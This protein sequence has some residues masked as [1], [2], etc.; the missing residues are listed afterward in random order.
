[1]RRVL[2]GGMLAFLFSAC[3]ISMSREDQVKNLLA[4]PSLAKSEREAL[5]GPFFKRTEWPEK[6]WWEYYGSEELNRLVALALKNNPTIQLVQSRI[7]FAREKALQAR[8]KLFPLIYFNVSDAWQYLSENGLYRALND[9]IQLS[10]QDIDFSLSFSYEFDFWGKYRNL[11]YAALGREKAVEAE[12][13][14]AELVVSTALAQAYFALKTNLARKKLYEKLYAVRKDLWNLQITLRDSA[15]ASDLPQLLSEEG[16]LEAKQWLASIDE[17]IAINRHVVNILAGRGPDESLVL[18][19]QL[20]LLPRKLALPN[21]LSLEL[22]SRRPDLM[23]EV[24]RMD[25]LAREVGA[26]KADFWPNINLTALLGFESG[27][28]TELFQWASKTVGVTP[29]LSLPVYTAGAI[30]A[31]VGEKRALFNEAVYQY[32]ELVLRSFQEVADLIAMGR[33]IYRQ[34]EEQE[35]IVRRSEMRYELVQLRQEHGIDDALKADR[36][37][38][39]VLQKQLMDVKLLYNQYLVS[40][41]L[42]KALG[43]GYRG[44]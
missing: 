38:E 14:Q 33:S 28:W 41:R 34:K 44:H 11:Y 32:N 3:T 37:L 39:E 25:A 31:N 10:N 35:A 43:G 23:A 18:E 20:P 1:M 40:V 19:P 13:V 4:A 9:S 16:V 7:T 30:A 24:W 5:A 22:L 12:N 29:G 36:F 2:L 8:S 21:D 42:I 27:S 15:L 6:T 26:A 17:E